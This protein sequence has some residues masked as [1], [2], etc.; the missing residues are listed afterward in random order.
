MSYLVRTDDKGGKKEMKKNKKRVAIICV[1]LLIAAGCTAVFAAKVYEISFTNNVKTGSVDIKIEQYEITDEG[2]KL[3]DP[4]EVMPNQDVSYIPRVT[5]LRNDGYVRVKAEIEMEKEITRPITLDC[6]YGLNEEWIRV[7][8]YYYLTKVLKTGESSDIFEG[9]N[10]PASWTQDDACGFTIKLTAD[11]VQDDFFEPDFKSLAPWG[12]IEIEQ[13]K[14][15]D[16]ITYG[17][18]KQISDSPVW[19]YTQSKGFETETKDLF[20]NFDYFMAGDS[21]KDTLQ[22]KNS[23]NNDIIVYFKT[24]TENRDLLEQMQLKITCNGK[25]VYEG[26]LASTKLN[27]YAELTTI[28]KGTSQDFEFEVFLPEESQNFYSVLEDNVIW[29]F[30]VEEIEKHVKTGDD[31]DALPFLAVSVIAFILIISLAA[32]RRKPDEIDRK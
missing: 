2:E 13:A 4:G 29:Q 15:E 23:C 1:L 8:D 26:K 14:E 22:M 27:K 5:N 30:K 10:V 21:Y 31:F 9:F 7:G 3:I 32:T 19:E 24:T 6:V 18:A 20:K 12:S 17:V 25:A 28:K 11:V 16:N